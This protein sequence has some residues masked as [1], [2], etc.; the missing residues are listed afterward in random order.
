MGLL[1]DRSSPLFQHLAP[2]LN[3]LR[4]GFPHPGIVGMPHSLRTPSADRGGRLPIGRDRESSWRTSSD[5]WEREPAA[6]GCCGL[7]CAIESA[8]NLSS[9]SCV[10]LRSRYHVEKCCKTASHPCSM[11]CEAFPCAA[12]Q[13]RLSMIGYGSSWFNENCVRKYFRL[14]SL[15]SCMR[16]GRR[17]H[18]WGKHPRRRVPRRSP[19]AEIGRR[20][21]PVRAWPW[22]D[23]H[24][25]TPAQSGG[26]LGQTG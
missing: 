4:S 20:G 17:N 13:V 22:R 7:R 14:I 5:K 16:A 21:A 6:G 2:T 12:L 9:T 10:I 3:A 15:R 18:L 24:A 23:G 8:K 19:D 11:A 26:L 1:C 25:G